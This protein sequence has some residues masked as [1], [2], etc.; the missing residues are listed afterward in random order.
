MRLAIALLAVTLCA[1]T[2]PWKWDKGAKTILPR[3]DTDTVKIGTTLPD[4]APANS[5]ALAGRIF[6]SARPYAAGT[7]D[8]TWLSQSATIADGTRS[9]KDASRV[10]KVG[11]TYHVWVSSFVESGGFDATW[12]IDHLTSIDKITWAFADTAIESDETNS[13]YAPDVAVS[14]GTYYLFYVHNDSSAIQINYATAGA[15]TGPWT[16]QGAALAKEASACGDNNQSIYD[17][18]VISIGGTWYL[19][20]VGLGEGGILYA[21]APSL[22]GPFTR[23]CSAFAPTRFPMEAPMVA[24]IGDYYHLWF[25]SE[26]ASSGS[27]VTGHALSTDGVNWG[28]APDGYFADAYEV[29]FFVRASDGVPVGSGSPGVWEGTAGDP[30]FLLI[31]ARTSGN[32][33]AIGTAQLVPYR[34]Q[35]GIRAIWARAATDKIAVAGS[36][37][38]YATLSTIP[39][40]LPAPALVKI[41]WNGAVGSNPLSENNNGMVFKVRMQIDGNPLPSST[42]REDD[43]DTITD[44]RFYQGRRMSRMIR[45]GAGRHTIE[46]MYATYINSAAVDQHLSV[47][48]PE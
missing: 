33:W 7:F 13:Y 15:P 25:S 4:G 8:L 34:Q 17:P 11:S 42:A 40:Y 46:L 21:T 45:L 38:N 39:I 36:G 14:D 3:R 19:Y 31:Q 22:A 35:L 23:Q 20:Y 26:I 12:R 28:W 9:Y 29:P 47:I 37:G 41:D 10:L 5:V 48:F 2:N 30:P 43:I 32:K 44:A 24:H 1:Q 18:T 6:T 16:E 27:S